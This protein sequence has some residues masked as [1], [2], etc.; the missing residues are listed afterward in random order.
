MSQRG[1][2]LII[3]RLL[4]DRVFR[5]RVER[6]G[7]A[8][9]AGLR[10][11]GLDLTRTEIADLIGVDPEVWARV[12]KQ[13]ALGSGRHIRA[14][15]ETPAQPVLTVPQERV[16]QGVCRGLSNRDIATRLGRSESA[17][18]AVLQQ[19]FRK[20]SVRR[21]VQLVRLALD[22]PSRFVDPSP[23]SRPA[24]P[25]ALGDV[26]DHPAAAHAS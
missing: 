23:S 1:V 7:S 20:F 25:A 4:T 5:R 8:Y 22:E 17:V 16:L 10:V 24:S 26:A 21:R 12:A 19:L 14:D 11:R 13:I 2:Q 9:L 6:G 18:K 15:A 3:G